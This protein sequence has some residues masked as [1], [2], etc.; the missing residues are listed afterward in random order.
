MNSSAAKED[1]GDGSTSTA[2]NEYKHDDDDD[3][4]TDNRPRKK[5][6]QNSKPNN[7]KK[8]Q[9]Q[10]QQLLNESST[11]DDLSTM[12]DASAYLSWV[13]QQA[14]SL[15]NV[16]VAPAAEQ[17][18]EEGNQK[19]KNDD[20]DN[21]KSLQTTK[22]NKEG[23]PI[24]DGSMASIQVLLSTRMDIL[25]PPTSRHLP[26]SS[27]SSSS[28]LNNNNN[29]NTLEDNDATTWVTNT[30]SNFSILRT[31]LEHEKHSL[32]LQ[33]H[34]NNRKIAVPRMKDRASWHIFCLG[35]EEAFGNVGGYYE[36]EEEEEEKEE[37]NCC[38][39]KVKVSGA[40]NGNDQSTNT[41]NN[42]NRSNVT[43]DRAKEEETST[44]TTP[45]NQPPPKLI[46]NSNNVPPNGYKPT[47]SLI[48]QLD[49]VLTRTLFHHHVHYL[50]E[51]KF[52]LSYNR[53]LWMYTLLA[54]IEKPWHREECCGVRRVLRECCERRWKLKLPPL[55]DT[56]AADATAL[57]S[58]MENV[59][60]EP[61]TITSNNNKITNNKDVDSN[62]ASIWE[63]LALLNTL[64]AI[65][66][67]YY[68]QDGMDTLFR[69]TTTE[70]TTTKWRE[71]G[72]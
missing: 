25:P 11:I 69:V 34:T 50:C 16:F 51:W 15:P 39:G 41:N 8:K 24:I 20:D 65:T 1:D 71:D 13:N 26:P 47:T 60:K 21:D 38:D 30:I 27:S 40:D 44:S 33:P 72:G 55:I 7:G 42:V 49:Q 31:H 4:T 45:S 32:K 3:D 70:S 63:Q 12:V 23:I 67:I 61:T 2:A 62:A 53:C 17:E 57:G 29:S 5:R 58:M 22:L 66:G 48:V 28:S 54:N 68:E 10:A 35:K 14:K 18:D 9:H 64:I 56:D 52:P 37:E 43:G 46:Y 36:E 59:V 19:M 6:K